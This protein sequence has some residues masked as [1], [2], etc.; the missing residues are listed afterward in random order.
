MI[1]HI[2]EV[3]HYTY[4][5]QHISSPVILQ[6]HIYMW[7]SAAVTFI[8][9]KYWCLIGTYT[10]SWWCLQ[11]P[12]EST[13]YWWP[14]LQLSLHC[15]CPGLYVHTWTPG[16][17]SLR[18]LLDVTEAGIQTQRRSLPTRNVCS[19]RQTHRVLFYSLAALYVSPTQMSFLSYTL[20]IHRTKS[21][22]P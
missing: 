18:F 11:R 2:T 6:D 10:W 19:C 13:Q 7:W 21:R 8:N 16:H 12:P 4:N 20:C 9:N 22:I 15:T 14:P 3:S 5:T 17:E 1:S